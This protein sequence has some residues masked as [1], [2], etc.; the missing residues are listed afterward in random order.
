MKAPVVIY[1]LFGWSSLNIMTDPIVTLDL[2]E[3]RIN[4]FTKVPFN[5]PYSEWLSYT[6]EIAYYESNKKCF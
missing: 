3:N 1:N 4:I 6:N 2:S 5:I